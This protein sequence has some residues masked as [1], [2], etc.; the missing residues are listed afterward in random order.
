M[1]AIET[2]DL[3]RRFRH[4]TAVDRLTLEVAGGSVFALIGSNGAGKSTALRLLMNIVEPT[5]G[6]AFVLGQPCRALSGAGFRKIAY[7]AEDQ[8]QPDWMTIAEFLAFV[9]PF[10]PDWDDSLA[11]SLIRE[12][13]LPLNRKLKH[14]SRGMRM[15]AVLVSSLAYRPRLIVLDEPFSGLDPLV[16]DEF[17]ESLIDRAPETTILISSHDLAEIEGLAT[18]IGF[19]EEG[20]L[21]FS[22]EI[23]SLAARMREVEVTF[24]SPPAALP[25]P[26]PAEWLNP[27][28]SG[29]V[30]RYVDSRFNGVPAAERFPTAAAPVKSIE[31][32]A[33]TLRTM[34]VAIAKSARVKEGG[35]PR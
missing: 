15:K 19:M 21:S 28:T 12:F 27:Q 11:A 1:N 26:W 14:L 24:E 32:R 20:R 16:R 25:Q 2:R 30:L 33:L 35:D 7:V 10:Y 31:A 23:G 5:S 22:E 17:V 3:T 6:E 18:H 9:K 13:A 8:E 4:V 34:F 29:V